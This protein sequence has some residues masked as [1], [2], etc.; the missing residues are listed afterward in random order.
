MCCISPWVSRSFTERMACVAPS[1]SRQAS[2]HF[3]LLRMQTPSTAPHAEPQS[4]LFFS[5]HKKAIISSPLSGNR[6]FPSHRVHLLQDPAS[7]ILA[8]SPHHRLHPLIVLLRNTCSYSLPSF[9]CSIF[10]HVPSFHCFHVCAVFHCGR[11]GHC[12]PAASRQ[13][14]PQHHL[15]VHGPVRYSWT[16]AGAAHHRPSRRSAQ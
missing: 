12:E 14:L 6:A 5:P 1:V 2:M 4:Y 15:D 10:V 13:Q 9:P 3:N 8:S 16:Q 7:I 11:P